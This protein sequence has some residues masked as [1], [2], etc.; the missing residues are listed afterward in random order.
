[1]GCECNPSCAAK[2]QFAS[3]IIPRQA[4]PRDCLR[5]PAEYYG[6]ACVHLPAL[7]CACQRTH[8]GKRLDPPSPLDCGLLRIY[9]PGTSV[10]R[11]NYPCVG[12]SEASSLAVFSGM[13]GAAISPS[14]TAPAWA[15]PAGVDGE[16][17]SR[18]GRFSL[19][20]VTSVAS[21]PWVGSGLRACCPPERLACRARSAPSTRLPA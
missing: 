9:H 19:A 18:L 7:G 15:G 4:Q 17:P 6:G 3:A 20:T 12:S 10:H 16:S 14:V 8:C 11:A 5:A 1:M 21:T 13:S 2:E